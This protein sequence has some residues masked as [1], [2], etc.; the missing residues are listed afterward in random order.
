MGDTPRFWTQHREAILRKRVADGVA[1]SDIARELG[2]KSAAAISGKVDRLKIGKGRRNPNGQLVRQRQQRAKRLQPAAVAIATT[3]N[4]R[5]Q[6]IDP[7][8]AIKAM[9]AGEVQSRVKALDAARNPKSLKS[10]MAL[11]EGDCRYPYT[12]GPHDTHVGFCG[13]DGVPGT[14]YCPSHLAICIPGAA[15]NAG[16]RIAESPTPELQPTEELELV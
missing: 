12:S 15:L 13:R 8:A 1:Y 9:E 6:R 4:R 10:I 3:G 5:Q 16:F 2:A 14:P 7:S 11:E